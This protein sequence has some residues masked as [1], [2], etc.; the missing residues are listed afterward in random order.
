MKE[1]ISTNTAPQAIGPY[2]QAVKSDNLIF[3]S[4]QIALD[5]ASG[6]MISEDIEEQT[7]QVL[8]NLKAIIN[9]AGSDLDKVTTVVTHTPCADNVG[10]RW[11]SD[12]N[13]SQSSR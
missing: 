13:N 6:E 7:H 4:G 12:I 8:K 1:I 2:S 5:P 9:S 10:S 11:L 3:V